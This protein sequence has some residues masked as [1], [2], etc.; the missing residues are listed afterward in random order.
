M[1]KKCKLQLNVVKLLMRF[2]R[3]LVLVLDNWKNIQNLQIFKII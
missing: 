3:I 1:I 2:F